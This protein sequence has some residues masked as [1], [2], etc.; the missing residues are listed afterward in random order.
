MI[1]AAIIALGA[2]V[3]GLIGAAITAI[4]AI[5]PEVSQGV[6]ILVS[7]AQVMWGFV[8]SFFWPGLLTGLLGVIVALTVAEYTYAA[9]M[10]AIAKIPM[11]SVE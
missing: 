3:A 4:P 5:P 10:W 8:D 9:V 6:G 2:V 7:Y 11:L 1:I